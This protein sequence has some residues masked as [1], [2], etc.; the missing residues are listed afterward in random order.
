[1]KVKFLLSRE[2]IDSQMTNFVGFTEAFM[3]GGRPLCRLEECSFGN[4]MTD[5]M[6][7]EMKVDIAVAN[8]G[9]IKGSFQ[10]GYKKV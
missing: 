5:A 9:C 4:F 8:A 3:D 6:A 10:K 2:L 1:V 7:A